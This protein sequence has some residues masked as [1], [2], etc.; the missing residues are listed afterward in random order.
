MGYRNAIICSVD[1]KDPTAPDIGVPVAALNDPVAV[2]KAFASGEAT[3]QFMMDLPR[4]CG[5]TTQMLITAMRYLIDHP[6]KRVFLCARSDTA[7]MFSTV[8]VAHDAIH[9]TDLR[10][11][12]FQFGVDKR[13]PPTGWRDQVTGLTKPMANDYPLFRAYAETMPSIDL[14]LYDDTGYLELGVIKLV[15]GGDSTIDQLQS[16]ARL[17]AF[18]H[19]KDQWHIGYPAVAYEINQ[20]Y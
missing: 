19:T 1:E 16:C 2:F 15:C 8:M 3:G 10:E 17:F 13:D 12:F 20:L 9:G 14:A 18:T 6:T 7:S 5:K 4:Q 11:R